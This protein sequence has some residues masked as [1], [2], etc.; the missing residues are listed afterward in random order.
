M[1]DYIKV[2]NVWESVSAMYKKEN[3]TWVQL[4]QSDFES[5]ITSN[6]ITFGGVV[7]GG[8]T[9][10]IGGVSVVSGVSCSFTAVYDNVNEVT[11]SATWSIVSGS[12]YATISNG[13]LTILS[14][15]N[16]S[17]VVIGVNYGGASAEKEV[18]V[19]YRYGS[20]A[21]TETTITT[22]ES[23]NTVAETTTII[24]NN[25]GSSEVSTSTVTYD[26]SGNTIGSSESNLTTNSDGSF[27]GSVTNYDE[28][29]VATDTTNQSGDTD[30]NVD[31]QDV[32][33]DASGNSIVTGYS[34]DTSN[35]PDGKK[36][37]TGDGVNTEFIPFA[38]GGSEGFFCH[39]VFKTVRTEQPRPPLVEDTE[40]TSNNWLY[41]IICA[42][43]P[44]KG[45]TSWPGFDIRWALSKKNASG[46]L[47]FRYS[48]KN[49]SATTSR[50]IA[51]LNDVYDLNIIYDPK[52]KQ[53]PSKFRC[54]S[55][56]TSMA[57]ISANVEFDENNMNFTLGYAVNQQG[58]P[59][60]Y[61]NVKIYEFT[62]RKL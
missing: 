26:E 18:T 37:I 3:S 23:G 33:Y 8:H 55:N 22:D 50:N 45:T 13:E 58:Q 53:Y 15:A 19:T 44:F 56:N 16:N 14:N 32:I 25:D 43:S 27:N 36:D 30:G 29:G 11:S 6:V 40:D 48:S 39:I 34:I 60:R 2:N 5:Y 28:N 47:Q 1:S 62:L 51:G 49:S 57:T 12:S 54:E 24:T 20:S 42:K 59:Y 46:N 7:E 31:T 41:N 4:T 61:S 17:I 10:Q 38:E 9:L 52:L 21:E 35:N